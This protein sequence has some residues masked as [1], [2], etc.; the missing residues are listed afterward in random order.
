MNELERSIRYWI[1]CRIRHNHK[2]RNIFMMRPEIKG[3]VEICLVC[4]KAIHVRKLDDKWFEE[5]EE[6]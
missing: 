3:Q 6:S 2:T 1:N 5:R 4:G